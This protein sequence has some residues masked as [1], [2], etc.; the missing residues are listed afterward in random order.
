MTR[1]ILLVLLAFTAVIIAGAM[2]PLTLNATSHDRSS[3]IQ[4]TAATARTDAAVA[5]ARLDYLY[6]I[7]SGSRTAVATNG[8]VDAPLLTLITKARQA[9]DGLL[10]LTAAT[11]EQSGRARACRPATGVSSPPRRTMQVQARDSGRSQPIQPVTETT[12][13]RVIAA[14][15][16][17][18]ARRGP[19]GPAGGH[20]DPGQVFCAAQ[21]RDH[22]AVGHPR[23]DRR[24]R[25]ARRGAAGVRAGPVGEQAA[26]RAGQRGPQAGRR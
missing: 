9:G 25:Y 12:G 3:F 6:S 7:A 5:Q 11:A 23:D 19:Q 20:G 15:R 1:R 4:A 14:M 26:G 22:R 17:L 2:V 21:P 8:P 13:S 24:R 10:I 18:R 16:R